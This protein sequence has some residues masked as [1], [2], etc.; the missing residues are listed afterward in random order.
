M[1]IS[2]HR[3]QSPVLVSSV[4]ILKGIAC[5][6]HRGLHYPLKLATFLLSLL[7]FGSVFFH[8]L[9]G[10]AVYTHRIGPHRW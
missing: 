7:R 6:D 4:G 1:Y 8:F 9:L 10:Q 5:I 3:C 2:Y